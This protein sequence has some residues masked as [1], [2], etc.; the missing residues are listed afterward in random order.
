MKKFLKTIKN[1]GN[2]FFKVINK[3]IVVP[4]SKIIFFI[5]KRFDKPGKQFENWLSRTNTLLF[6][7]LALAVIVFIIIDMSILTYSSSSAE[8]LTGQDVIALYDQDNYVVEGIPESVDITLIGDKVDLYIASQSPENSV[9]ID[10]WG[11]K[12]GKHEVALSYDKYDESISYSVNPSVATV[13]IYEKISAN[14]TVS[15][16]IL[17]QDALDERYI[18]DEVKITDDSAVIKGSSDK[19]EQVAT[20]KA[21]LDINNLPDYELGEKIVVSTTLKAYDQAG[22][23]VDVEISPAKMDVEV[24]IDS[25]SKEVPLQVVPEG[26]VAYNMGIS[27]LTLNSSSNVTVTLYGTSE[28]LAGI[29]Y[30]P[31]VVNVE[32]LT[33]SAE[34][35]VQLEKPTGVKTMSITNVTV[36]VELSSDITNKDIAD[37]GITQINLGSSYG[38]T[39]VDVDSVTVKLKGETSVVESVAASDITAYVDLKGLGVGIHEVSVVVTGTDPRVEYQSSVIKIKVEIFQK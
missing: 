10:L 34:F 4:I 11:L 36:G 18:I 33:E 8:V 38:V 1:I 32:G 16:D 22:N 27:R 6:V 14:K 7:S 15:V 12:P 20:V 29:D 28:E 17:N 35:K 39:P 2:F 21:L 30:I 26:N 37:I 24:L 23:V 13:F 3:F 31:V 19:V 5:N 25:P 9:T